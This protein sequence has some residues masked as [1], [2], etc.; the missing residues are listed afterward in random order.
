MNARIARRDRGAGRRGRLRPLEELLGACTL[1]A[2]VLGVPGC[3][4]SGGTAPTNH[5]PRLEEVVARPDAVV[6][7]GSTRVSA[8]GG[9]PDGNPVDF[10]WTA[11]GGNFADSTAGSTIWTAPMT[12]GTYTLRVSL[13]DGEFTVDGSTTIEAGNAVLTVDSD[14]PG[15]V[16]SLD[17]GPTL[18]VTPHTFDPVAPGSHPV[19]VAE[20]DFAYENNPASVTLVHGESKTVTFTI[21]KAV[22]EVM[23]LGRDDFLEIGGLAWLPSGFGLVYS[24]RTSEGTGVFSS[25]LNPPTGTPNGLHLLSGVKVNEPLALSGD[26]NWLFYVGDGGGVYSVAVRDRDSDG[27]IDSVG[28]PSRQAFSGYGPATARDLPRLAYGETPAEDPATIQLFWTEFT[29]GVTE[30]PRFATTVAGKLPTWKADG[31]QIA[32]IRDGVLLT[33][34]IISGGISSADTVV[35]GD[36]TYTAPTWGRWGNQPIA[37]LWG[38]AGAAPTEMRFAV[39]S[40]PYSASV[41]DTPEAPAFIAWSP[42]Q[43]WLAMSANPGGKGEILLVYNLPIAGL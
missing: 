34:S 19:S 31:G 18:Y 33:A 12:P 9:D 42:A 3:G 15:A 7:G 40:S 36:G 5:P 22:S 20:T 14:P 10:R 2:L 6:L 16:I 38:A 24:A 11:D 37:V 32:F 28:T 1:G 30:G 26:G 21:P 43:A 25:A 29:D 23:D 13:T 4:G 41:F 17:L 35:A 27:R 39:T 8:L